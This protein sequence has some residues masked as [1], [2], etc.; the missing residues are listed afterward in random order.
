MRLPK[1]KTLVWDHQ[2]RFGYEKR[3]EKIG[4][5]WDSKTGASGAKRPAGGGNWW[6]N[7]LVQRHLNRLICGRPLPG[8]G[9]GVREGMKS[10]LE[11][12]PGFGRAVSI[13]CGTAEKELRLISE[14]II[15]H[16]DLYELSETRAAAGLGKAT[17]VGVED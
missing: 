11:G 7:S 13:G 16:F 14:G 5:V 2:K 15:N 9:A 3:P 8:G 10:I 6:G 17:A 4:D 12:R 1:S